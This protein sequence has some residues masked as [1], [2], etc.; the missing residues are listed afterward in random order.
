MSKNRKKSG[1]TGKETTLGCVL[2]EALRSWPMTLALLAS[3]GLAVL[4]GLIP[5]VILEK[6]VDLLTSG[7]EVT[8][9]RTLTFGIIYFAV[10]ALAGLSESAREVLITVFGQRITHALRSRLCGKIE[11]LPSAS[12]ASE[13]AGTMVSLIT[14]DVG[15]IERLFES[16]IIGV[17][18]DVVSVV[19]IWIMICTRNAGLALVLIPAFPFVIL[20][21]RFFRNTSLKAHSEG[22]RAAAEAVGIVPETLKNIRTVKVYRREGFAEERYGKAVKAG[23]DAAEKSNFCDAVYSPVITALSAFFIA[24]VMIMASNVTGA[25]SFFGMSVGTS[26]AVIAYIGKIFGPIESIGME[27]QNIQ[28]AVAGIKRIDA[29][30]ALGER[31]PEQRAGSVPAYEGSTAVAIDRLGFSYDG[32]R[33]VIKDFSLNVDAGENITLAGRT[34]AGKSTCLKLV[35]GL[36]PAGEGSIRIFGIPAE[37]L[38]DSEKRLLFGYVEQGFKPVPGSIRDQITLGDKRVDDGLVLKAVRIAGLD[39]IIE[40]LEKG[41]DTPF[42]KTELSQGQ[43]QLLSIARAIVL[44]PKIML[45]DEITANLDSITEE[46]VLSAM[47]SASAN[48]AVLSVSHRLYEK[49]T[50]NSRLVFIG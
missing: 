12:L 6:I 46:Q 49:N 45:L 13:S 26:V 38:P 11:R 1:A 15:T 2:K 19:G 30:L 24:F 20:F 48:R 25:S 43:L 36:Y 34:G 47:N 35:Q 21:T 22:R 50:G 33:D 5:P 9:G 29:F 27:I 14:G 31:R 37:E 3:V 42:E 16:G 32:K 17:I 7:E 8:S 10:A 23:F 18:A 28:S 39:G 40:G 41:L 44:E 4:L